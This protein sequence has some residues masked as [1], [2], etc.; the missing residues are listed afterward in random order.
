MPNHHDVLFK[1]IF[2]EPRNAREHFE[3]FLPPEVVATLDLDQLRRVP[4]SFVTKQSEERHT[5]LLFEAPSTT[6]GNAYVYLLF[7][8]QSTVDTFMPLRMLGYMVNIWEAHRRDTVAVHTRS[9]TLPPIIPLVLYQGSERW[10]ASP[11]FDALLSPAEPYRPFVPDFRMLLTD[12]AREE[13][14][15]IGPRNAPGLARLLMKY[16]GN[17]RLETE[18]ASWGPH[19]AAVEGET[20]DLNHFDYLLHYLFGIQ[21][22]LA[23]EDVQAVLG[24]Y[25][26]PRGLERMMSIADQLRASGRDEGLRKGRKEGRKKGRQEGRQEELARVVQKQLTSKFGELDRG[27]IAR[28]AGATRQELDLWADRLLTAD[29]IEDVFQG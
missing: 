4:G 25:V 28:L 11:A 12:L 23:P 24:D 21:D 22:T 27:A 5:D 8:H 29:R 3:R 2:S 9:K 20:P 18:L 13:D 7:E 14:D 16:S 26:G 6:G 19:F 17:P 1:A 10:T 15:A